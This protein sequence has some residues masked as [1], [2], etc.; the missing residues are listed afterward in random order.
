MPDFHIGA[1]EPSRYFHNRENRDRFTAFEYVLLDSVPKQNTSA[2]ARQASRYPSLS[3]SVPKLFDSH[4][5]VCA[6]GQCSIAEMVASR[7]ACSRS[8]LRFRR[9]Q[10]L[11][12]PHFHHDPPR[13]LACPYCGR[14]RQPTSDTRFSEAS[15][16]SKYES[17]SACFIT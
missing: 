5:Y 2:L 3:L 11:L 12:S 4:T 17:A 16:P 14:P 15:A 9:E 6:A 1:L 7:E 8:V 13:P 10:S